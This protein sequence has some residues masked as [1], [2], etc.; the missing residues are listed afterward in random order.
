LFAAGARLG[1]YEIVSSL[2]RG[3][4]GEVSERRY[5]SAKDLRNDLEEL[6]ASIESGEL[7]ASP[8][9]TATTGRRAFA[10]SRGWSW[11]G[12]AAAT[13]LAITAAR[14]EKTR[15]AHAGS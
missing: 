15:S 2:G 5:Q 6:E 13:A 4:M 7:T 8:G 1:P 10:R 3:G 11:V 14:S 12:A 9:E